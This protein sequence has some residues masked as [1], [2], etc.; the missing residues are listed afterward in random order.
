QKKMLIGG[1]WVQA[2]SGETFDVFN[3]ADEELLA[4]VPQGTAEDVDT[5]VRAARKAFEQGPWSSISSA[6]RTKLLWRL[7]DLMEERQEEL[8]V[9]E[10]LDN[11]KPLH[12]ARGDVEFAIKMVRYMAGWATKLDGSTIDTSIDTSTEHFFAYTLREPMGVCGLITPWN[13]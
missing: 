5:A 12:K 11:G 13:F 10:T 4:K 7:A 6:D 9:L 2:S 8:S 1:E 3:P